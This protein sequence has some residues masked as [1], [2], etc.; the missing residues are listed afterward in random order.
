MRPPQ[1]QPL[2]LDHWTV[3]HRQAAQSQASIALESAL[4]EARALIK[5][6]TRAS[7]VHLAAIDDDGSVLGLAGEEVSRTAFLQV[8]ET[9]ARS[10]RPVFAA[11]PGHV[12]HQLR[13]ELGRHAFEG[14]CLLRSSASGPAFALAA[15]KGS[16]LRR[17]DDVVGAQAVLALATAVANARSTANKLR[18]ERLRRAVQVLPS[19]RE[20]SAGPVSL[21]RAVLNLRSLFQADAVTLL[22]HDGARLRLAASSDSRLSLGSSVHYDGKSG[23]SGAVFDGRTIRLVTTSDGGYVYR[24]AGLRR[25]G[26]QHPDRDESGNVTDVFLGVPVREGDRVLGVLRVTRLSKSLPFSAGDASDL[27]TISRL[28]GTNLGAADS[29]NLATGI[30]DTAAEAMIVARR[31]RL[32]GEPASTRVF[33]ANSG[34]ETL[35]GQPLKAICGLRPEQL[36]ERNQ[37]TRVRSGLRAALVRSPASGFG[38]DDAV[39]CQV[40]HATGASTQATVSFRV[41]R[42]LV[43]PRLVSYIVAVARPASEAERLAAEQRRLHRLLAAVGI[44]YFRADTNGRTLEASAVDCRLTGYSPDE[45]QSMS[46]VALYADPAKRLQLLEEARRSDGLN[47]KAVVLMRRKNG[48]LFWAGGDLLL[49][50]DSEGRESGV[51]GFYRDVSARIELQRFLNEDSDTLLSEAELLNRLKSD[52]SF[53]L[54][55]V[56]SIGHQIQTPLAAL[57]GVLENFERAIYDARQLRER[58]IYVKGQARTCTR[59]VKNLSYMGQILKGGAFETELVSLGKLAIETKLDLQHLLRARHLR[60]RIDDQSLESLSPFTGHADLLRQVFFNLIDNAIKYSVDGATI[61]VRGKARD[62]RIF[63][64][65]VNE[66]LRVSGSDKRRVFDRGFRTDEAKDLVPYGTGLGLWLVRR[67]IELHDGTVELECGPAS[68]GFRI[69]VRA[70]FP[71]R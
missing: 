57:V 21:K 24:S 58:I 32:D 33:M 15:L 68:R 9:A 18:L 12:T 71:R 5:R 51:E 26:P 60:L 27:E 69:A 17:L 19:A 67:I 23:L 13:D 64:E 34:A 3:G 62:S 7:Q 31:E 35:L 61:E 2:H 55:Y 48:G 63:F 14:L 25:A 11:E 29:A 22:L 49:M 56:S 46:R 54:D 47:S 30:F 6:T 59:L 52:A 37:Q 10:R 28:L 43:W 1:H 4:D 50:R 38:L 16:P 42:S 65:V 20:L 40:S 70:S 53:N 45:L 66:G 36:L 41:V 8:V 39:Q 44:A